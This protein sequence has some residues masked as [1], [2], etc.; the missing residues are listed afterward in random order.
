MKKLVL[1][2]TAAILVVV[3]AVGCSD[4]SVTPDETSQSISIPEYQ[5]TAEHYRIEDLFAKTWLIN[6]SLESFDS[7]QELEE[8]SVGI[9]QGS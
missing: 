8:G 7:R 1:A 6:G 4:K 3:S 9:H 2:L 5:Y